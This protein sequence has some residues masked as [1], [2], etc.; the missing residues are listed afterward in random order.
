[1]SKGVPFLFG[2]AVI[3]LITPGTDEAASTER[4][5]FLDKFGYPACPYCPVAR[6][7]LAELEMELGADTFAYVE[8]H[9]AQGLVV[10]SGGA[11]WDAHGRPATP[12]LYFDGLDPETRGDNVLPIYRARI[13]ARALVPAP[14]DVAATLAF[15][16]GEASGTITIE[17]TLV[18][19]MTVP[20]PEECT[21]RAVLYE[22]A[23]DWCCGFEGRSMWD[24]VTREFFPGATLALGGAPLRQTLVI[25]F[26]VAPGWNAANLRAIAFVQ[27]GEPGEVL[28]AAR[29]TPDPSSIDESSWG[30]VKA[31]YRSDP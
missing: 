14:L 4:L 5:V 8:T 27:R 16:A 7:A 15:D 22:D 17:V 10:P 6:D 19:G 20:N 12:T 26:A 1:M 9:V 24:R 29:A 30:R 21:V 18:D 3:A 23:V 13:E 28:N 11:R 31:L 2:L 25:P